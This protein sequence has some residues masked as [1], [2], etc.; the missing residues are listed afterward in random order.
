MVMA[1]AYGMTS[2]WLH[3]CR[4]VQQGTITGNER[5]IASGLLQCRAGD[6]LTIP[7]VYTVHAGVG[8]PPG[9]TVIDNGAGHSPRDG[10]I[11]PGRDRRGNRTGA[12]VFRATCPGGAEG[13]EQRGPPDGSR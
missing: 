4:I 10:V 5:K 11:H 9:F 6:Y 12:A 2:I 3:P 13:E 8:R 1:H 7:A